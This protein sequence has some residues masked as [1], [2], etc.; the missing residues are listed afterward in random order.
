MAASALNHPN[1]C[2]VY[3][4]I[5]AG[6]TSFIVMELVE[7]KTLHALLANGPRSAKR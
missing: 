4:L 3:D 2:T 1:I 5:E 6:E 7:G